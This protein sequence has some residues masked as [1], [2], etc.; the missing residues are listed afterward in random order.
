MSDVQLF[1]CAKYLSLLTGNADA[2]RLPCC[3][4]ELEAKL[5]EVPNMREAENKTS[6]DKGRMTELD[7]IICADNCRVCLCMAGERAGNKD[8]SRAEGKR[9]SS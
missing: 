4:R 9:G 5:V 2:I 3:S 6:S 8:G 1:V 7:C